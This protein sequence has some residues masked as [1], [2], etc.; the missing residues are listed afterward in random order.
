MVSEISPKQDPSG[1]SQ[2]HDIS[3][4]L[5]RESDVVVAPKSLTSPVVV[6]TTAITNPNVGSKHHESTNPKTATSHE[7]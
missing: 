1:T 4:S 7:D 6:S 5:S 2:F 3:P